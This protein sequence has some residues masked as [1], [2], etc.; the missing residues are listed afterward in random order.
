MEGNVRLA[1]VGDLHCTRKSEGVYRHMFARMSD[2]ADIALICG[3]LTDYGLP[4]EAE[5][6]AHE[7]QAG[8]SIPSVAVLGNHDH[9]SNRADQV[10]QILLHAGVMVLEGDA[11]EVRGIGFAGIKGF[12]GGFGN[13]ALEPWGEEILKKFVQET[14]DEALKLEKALARVESPVKIVLMH[15]APIMDTVRGEPPEIYP[16]LGSR[17]LEEPLARYHVAAVFHGHAHYGSPE[18]RTTCGTAVYNVA[19]PLLK[20]QPVPCLYR[21]F[22]V[23]PPEGD[24]ATGPGGSAFFEMATSV[25][26]RI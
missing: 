20:R 1:A 24:A 10:R 6:L 23:P 5:I 4:E 17:R 15:Y 2:E 16:F 14:I 25:V 18:G 8:L 11:C 21:I 13:R 26:E 9:E 12:C 19:M 22:D 3:D 7:I